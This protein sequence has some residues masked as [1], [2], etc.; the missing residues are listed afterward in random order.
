MSRNILIVDDDSDFL[1]IFS[2]YFRIKGFSVD[3][4][5]SGE[6]AI[7]KISDFEFDLM[8]LDIKLPDMLGDEV[9]KRVR[10]R[11]EDV[12]IIL[13]TGYPSLQDSIDMLGFRIQ[14]ILLKPVT[15]E[16]ML[17]AAHYPAP[18]TDLDG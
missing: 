5:S 6:E 7:E 1:D 11:N 12:E 3:V 18:A 17:K 9:V 8:I 13:I 14:E 15:P 10:A 16:E 4:A 2:R